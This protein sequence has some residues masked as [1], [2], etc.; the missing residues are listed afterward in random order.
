MLEQSEQNLNDKQKELNS[1]ID[2]YKNLA[3]DVH[4]KIAKVAT[5]AKNFGNPPEIHE[6]EKEIV[7]EQ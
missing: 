5:D 3:K 1:L 7:A 4:E 6:P 2:S